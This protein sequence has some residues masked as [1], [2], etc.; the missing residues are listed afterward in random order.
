MGSVPKSGRTESEVQAT[1]VTVDKEDHIIL[2]TSDQLK[3]SKAAQ[4]GG[5]DTFDLFLNKWKNS[6]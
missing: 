3:F 4:E 1:A 5:G 2:S 6:R